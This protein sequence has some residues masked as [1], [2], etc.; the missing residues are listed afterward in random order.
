[1]ILIKNTKNK[2][3]HSNN[4]SKNLSQQHLSYNQKS[5]LLY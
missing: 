4:K 3:P 2:Q 1:M 5:V